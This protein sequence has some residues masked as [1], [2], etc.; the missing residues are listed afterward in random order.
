MPQLSKGEKA[1]LTISSDYVSSPFLYGICVDRKLR[2]TVQAAAHPSSQQTQSS[3][4][5]LS[6]STSVRSNAGLRRGLGLVSLLCLLYF[7]FRAPQI[8]HRFPIV[9]QRILLG[10]FGVSR[11]IENCI[12]HPITTVE[13]WDSLVWRMCNGRPEC[14]SMSNVVKLGTALAVRYF[15]RPSLSAPGCR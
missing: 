9:V 2:R 7:P 12:P 8:V 10:T 4:S 3:S 11:M 15:L 6:S 14:Q 1:N 13:V 5:R